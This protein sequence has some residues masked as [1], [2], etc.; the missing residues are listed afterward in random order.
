MATVSLENIFE[1]I[2]Q[3]HQRFDRLDRIIEPMVS[4]LDNIEQ[5]QENLRASVEGHIKDIRADIER[6]LSDIGYMQQDAGTAFANRARPSPPSQSTSCETSS[7]VSAPRWNQPDYRAQRGI[8]DFDESVLWADTQNAARVR[9][10]DFKKVLLKLVEGAN[11]PIE[12]VQ[13]TGGVLVKNAKL[14]FV[15]NQGT[16][17]ASAKQ[18]Y[19]YMRND[20]Q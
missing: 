9:F 10:E 15:G 4:R 16:A 19:E 11:V 1:A 3:Q 7:N 20:G 12:R 8:R 14:R 6:K 5:N 18:I 17:I 2:Q 13:T